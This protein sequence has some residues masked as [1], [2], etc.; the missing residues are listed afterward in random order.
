MGAVRTGTVGPNQ[1]GFF[2]GVLVFFLEEIRLDAV[3][4]CGVIRSF[5]SGSFRRKN[6]TCL[7]PYFLRPF[8]GRLHHQQE[9]VGRVK[10][11]LI[12]QS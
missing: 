4:L 2:V 11:L 5:F 1:M 8:N 10:R 6:C 12:A 3:R 7:S 9:I